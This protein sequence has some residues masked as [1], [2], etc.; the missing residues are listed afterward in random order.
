MATLTRNGEPSVVPVCFVYSPGVVYS[1]IDE[2]PKKVR[3]SKLRRIRNIMENPQVSL[4]VDEYRE[5]WRRLRFV[6]IR[7]RATILTSGEEHCVAISLLRKK[8]S[9]YGSMRLEERPIIRIEP[10]HTIAWKPA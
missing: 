1:A 7:G 3:L 6:I 8:Y 5:D 9:Q 2:K 10:L 4:V